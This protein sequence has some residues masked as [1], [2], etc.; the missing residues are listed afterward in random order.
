M[1]VVFDKRTLCFTSNFKFVFRPPI[2]LCSGLYLGFFVCG[3]K[4]RLWGQTPQTFTGISRIQTG[5]LVKHY[6]RKKKLVFLAGATAPHAP[7]PL[8]RYVRPWNAVTNGG[9]HFNQS[10]RAILCADQ[11]DHVLYSRKRDGSPW[12][13]LKYRKV[14]SVHFFKLTV[15]LCF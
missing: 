3:G 1:N 7:P 14:T 13:K 11:T 10:S 15:S 9:F 4:L 2:L 8:P 5:F 6:V 12:I